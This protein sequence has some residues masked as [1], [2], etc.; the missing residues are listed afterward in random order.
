MKLISWNRG[1]EEL[2]GFR[3]EEVLGKNAR[4]IGF[5]HLGYDEIA[6]VEA[7]IRRSGT[8]K[9]EMTFTHK[10]GSEFFGSITG[11]LVKNE[12]GDV[13]SF[14]FIV[15]DISPHKKLEDHLKKSKEKLE[16]EVKERTAI[17]RETEKKYRHLFDKNPL[18]MW[19][20]D[21]KDFRFLDVNETAIKHY[22]YSRE[23]FLS[24]NALDIR[25][26]E[27]KSSFRD[28][29]RDRRSIGARSDMGIWNHLKKDGSVIKARIN[30]H[31][32]DFEGKM[33]ALIQVTDET[34]KIHAEEKLVA[35]E[36]RFRTLIEKAN[37]VITLMDSDLNLIYRSPA[38]ERTTGWS[39]EEVLNVD[40]LQNVH[41]DDIQ[42]TK[43]ILKEVIGNPG[44]TF[45][46]T[47]RNRHKK[48]HYMWI[49]GIL[50]NRLQDENVQAIVFN[51]QDVTERIESAE[52]IAASEREYHY[53]FENSPLPMWVI[54]RET[55][56]FLAVNE[57][58]IA[59]YGYSRQ[60]FLSMTAFDIRPEADKEAFLRIDRTSYSKSPIHNSGVWNHIKKDGTLIK[61]RIHAHYMDFGGKSASLVL[62][63]DVTETIDAE[64]KLQAS[65]KRFRTLVEKADDVITLMD[66]SFKLIYRSPAAERV[67]GWSNEDMLHVNATRNIHPDDQAEAQGIVQQVMANPGVTYKTMFRN[68]H[69]KGHYIWMEGFVTNWLNDKNVNAIVFNY[70]DVTERITAAEKIAASEERYR[71]TLDNMIEGVQIIGFDWKYIFVNKAFATQA[72]IPKETLTGYPVLE[73]FPCLEKHPIYQACQQCFEERKPLQ[74]EYEFIFPDKTTGWYELSLQPVPE[75]VFILSVDITER[76]KSEAAL[77]AER[78]KLDKIAATAPGLLYSFR[79]DKNGAY[80]FPYASNAVEDIF[81]LSFRQIQENVNEVF[82]RIRPDAIEQL[83]YSIEKSARELTPWSLEYLYDHPQK[84]KIWLYGSSIPAREPDGSTI[85]HGIFSD[86]SKI[87]N[88]EQALQISNERFKYATKASSDIVWE[89]N[90]ETREYMVYE[91]KNK[92][93]APDEEL[94]WQTGVD[95]K[96]IIE[97]DRNRIRASFAKAKN[98]INQQLWNDEYGVYATDGSQLKVM[99]HAIFIRNENGEVTRVIGAMKDVTEQRKLETALQ[100]QQRREQMMVTAT[101]LEAQEKERN[102]I[103]MELHDN[104]N[105]LLVGA[106]ML[107]R[108][109]ANRPE[110]S[111]E[112]LNTSITHIKSAIDEN[113]KLAHELVTPNI[114]VERL[115][116]L[117]TELTSSTLVNAGLK[118]HIDHH[119]CKDC[120][121][122]NNLKLAAYRVAQEQCTNIIKYAKAQHVSFILSIHRNTFCM[123]IKDDGVGMDMKPGVKPTGIGLRNIA[124]RMSVINGKVD[125]NSKPGEGFTLLV[126]IPLTKQKPG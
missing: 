89:L 45:K 53:L 39:N 44:T 68:L 85:W 59:H 47:L 20:L 114:D 18:P 84:G 1:A 101:A 63:N 36:K 26:E 42:K 14:Y 87:K 22:G 4:E 65:E 74:Q 50:T 81:G 56:R 34:Q 29:K 66:S 31:Q 13:T 120:M 43:A 125:I 73:I 23:E 112:L 64:E 95:G 24:M 69:K 80:S 8:W 90:F 82:G 122:T 62:I 40:A 7:E 103:G 58:A 96:Y 106:Y 110:K 15:K 38:A 11:N 115:P 33:A 61:V 78:A 118:V 35:S 3:K 76:R 30:M 6:G 77:E 12:R 102:A 72:G 111:D 92:L 117:L 109:A 57:T 100:E 48:G 37:D 98:D 113:R 116:A 124:A 121:L 32:V 54:D 94:T 2:F 41:P 104:V 91:G 88:A 21:A 71:S 5:F 16:Q 119:Q 19:V 27:D 67:T 46:I 55:Y 93:F 25:P 126:K 123:E 105:Q 52:K 79:R 108:M 99:N 60:E 10:S 9:A 83:V 51:Y 86:V 70:K 97:K 28:F 49:E 75:G 17:I 107:L